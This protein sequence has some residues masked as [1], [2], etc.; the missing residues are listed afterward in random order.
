MDNPG[1]EVSSGVYFYRLA[2]NGKKWTETN[3]MVLLR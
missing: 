3:K 1:L 2:I